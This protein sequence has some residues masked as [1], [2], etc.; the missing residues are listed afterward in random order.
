MSPTNVRRHWGTLPRLAHNHLFKKCSIGPFVLL[1][2]FFFSAC[3]SQHKD[4][5][6]KL[7]E[8]SYSF[9]YR[10]LDSTR[11]YAERALSLS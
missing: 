11:V 10:N 2:F 3:S 7:N 4:E 1:G 5:V 9:H 8:L 6:D